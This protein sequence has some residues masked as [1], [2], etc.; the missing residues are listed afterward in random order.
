MGKAGKPGFARS[1]FEEMIDSGI[2]PNEKTLTAVIKIYGKA[3]WSKDALE[4]WK[5]MKENGWPMDFMLYNTLLS[6]CAD[7]GLLEEA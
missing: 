4:L 2:A 1:L 6:M 5:R 3:R 7:V